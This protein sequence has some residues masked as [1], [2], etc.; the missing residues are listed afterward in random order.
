MAVALICRCTLRAVGLQALLTDLGAPPIWSACTIAEARR[1]FPRHPPTHLLLDFVLPDACGPRGLAVLRLA[2][3]TLLAAFLLEDLHPAALALAARAGACAALWTTLPFPTLR[4]RLQ[5]FLAGRLAWTPE[6]QRRIA[7]W[8]TNWGTPWAALSPR[9]RAV[10]L[11]LAAGW[12]DKEIARALGCRPTSVRTHL[13]ALLERLGL[14]DRVAVRQWVRM[15]R[16]NDPCIAPLLD[17]EEPPPLSEDR[18]IGVEGGIPP[19]L[20]KGEA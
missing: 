13:H 4:A 20:R 1:W 5:D 15:G 19:T 18:L 12:S 9:Q 17:L 16:L 3:P 14:P 2:H 6:E 10:A 11:G 7:Q 8:W